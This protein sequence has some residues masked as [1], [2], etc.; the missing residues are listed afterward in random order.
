MVDSIPEVSII[1]VTYSS[2]R[3]IISCLNSILTQD[4]KDYEIIAIDNNSGDNTKDIIE[5][6]YPNILLMVN[7]INYGTSKARNQGLAASSGKFILFLD[8]DVTLSPGFLKN[9]YNEINR[10]NNVAAVQPKILLQD[11]KTI[12]STG[13]YSSLLWRFHDM[14]SGKQDGEELNEKRYVF[15]TSV[16]AS[17]YRKE[18]LDSI[19]TNGEYFDEDFFYFFEDV[20]LSWRLRRRGWRITYLPEAS[21]VHIAG[22]SRNPDKISQYYCVRNRYLTILKNASWLGFLRF[23]LIF[24]I[25]DFWRNLILLIFNAHYFF[26]T[27]KD[28]FLLAPKMLKKRVKFN[29]NNIT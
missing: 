12:Y 11:G 27:V 4:F 28:C 24:F 8:H 9:I 1:I 26:K 15:G 21:C 17:I 19:K 14:G 23:I 7:E 18:A 13:I 5:Q 10:H 25:Y 2:S 20:D 29:E 16:A 3:Y 22:R 6:K